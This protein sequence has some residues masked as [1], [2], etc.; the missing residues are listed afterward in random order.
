MLT[1]NGAALASNYTLAG[2]I[3][4]VTITPLPITVNAIAQNKT[5]DETTAATG[6]ARQHRRH[7][8]RCRHVRLRLGELRHAE[9]RG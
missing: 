9:R 5:Y 4:W 8:G 7:R 6:R 1:G 2:G 3:D